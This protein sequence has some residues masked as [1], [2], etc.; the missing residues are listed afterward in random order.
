[1][2]KCNKLYYVLSEKPNAE[3]VICGSDK[4]PSINGK[5]MFYQLC[6]GV[7]VHAEIEGL[8][9]KCNPFLGFHIHNGTQCTGNESDPFLNADGHYNPN[10]C[11]HPCH[12]G[13]MPPLFNAN[14]KAVLVFL[15]DKFTL[16]EILGK[17]V[18]IHSMPD[19]FTTQPSGNAG[20]KIAC[21][22]IKLLCR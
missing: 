22:T 5:V 15:T 9:K 10:N 7:I 11:P 1:M 21:G 16:S 17:A 6:G 12:A 20:E 8:P 4:Y 18:I 13:D 19:D 3:A 2:K 14:G